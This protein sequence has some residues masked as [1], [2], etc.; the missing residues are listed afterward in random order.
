MQALPVDGDV[1]VREFLAAGGLHG[2]STAD[3][4]PGVTHPARLKK[5]R[6]YVGVV[7]GMLR[8]RRVEH[9]VSFTASRDQDLEPFV[10]GRANTPDQDRVFVVHP[11]GSAPMLFVSGTIRSAEVPA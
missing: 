7:T 2:F 9:T 10:R 1:S 5:G 6:E 8:G 4:F 11:H 3:M